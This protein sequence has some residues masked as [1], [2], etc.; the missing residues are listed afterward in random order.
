MSEMFPQEISAFFRR[1]PAQG[2]EKM[3]DVLKHQL[4]DTHPDL[5]GFLPNPP[6][7]AL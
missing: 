6:G 7:R 3:F 5:A 2:V 4:D 1:S